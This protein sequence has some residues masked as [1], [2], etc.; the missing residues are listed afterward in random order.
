M[1][2]SEQINEIAAALAKAQAAI[3]NPAKESENPHFKSR[4]ADLATGLEAVRG[5]LATNA[6]A[7]MQ[8]EYM[9]GDILMLETRLAHSSGQWIASHY[10][11]CKFP[12]RHQEAGSALTYARRYS[13]FALVGIAGDDDDGNEASKTETPAPRKPAKPA[14]PTAA[15]T[16]VKQGMDIM[17]ACAS[18]QQLRDWWKNDADMRGHLFGGNAD[19]P[20]YMRLRSAYESRGKEL[21]EIENAMKDAA[22]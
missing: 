1:R 18:V 10:P 16:Y 5:P 6:I 8:A 19:D 22:E 11:V 15:Q 3:K 12:V 13:L 17:A 4:Y 7:L 21:T 9:E 2:T 14:V 20:D